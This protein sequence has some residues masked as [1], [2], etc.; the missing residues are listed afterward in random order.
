MK[1]SFL[2]PGQGAQYPGMC[3]DFYDKSETVRDLFLLADKVTGRDLKSL[4]FEG[5]AEDL[6]QTENTQIAVTL[7]NLSIRRYLIENGVQAD[8][9]AGFSLGEFSAMVE[10]GILTEKQVLPM[11]I[12]RGEIMARVAKENPALAGGSAMAAV[13]GMASADVSSNVEDIKDAYAA[14]FNAPTQTV[15]SG[16]VVGIEAAS[17]KLKEAGARRIIPLKVS[18]PFHTPLLDDAM[19]YFVEYISSL[20]FKDPVKPM[21]SNV[22]GKRVGSG[23]EAKELSGLQ[24]ISPVKWIDIESNI[25]S[26]GFD[27]IVELGPGK[28]LT[29]FW[30]SASKEISCLPTGSVEVADGIS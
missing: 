21:Y 15:I 23:V 26:E 9:T 8:G 2:F 24:I 19:K 3:K 30:K 29:G 18:G 25:L 12:E 27:S 13:I 14:N 28:V 5:T 17:A 7:M 22:T 11:V 10:A 20:E 6:K 16:T 1:R 4:L